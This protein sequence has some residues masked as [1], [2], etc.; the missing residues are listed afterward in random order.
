M[1]L[2]PSMSGAAL[3]DLLLLAGGR[4]LGD[5]SVTDRAR[6]EYV[7]GQALVAKQQWGEALA[8][9]ERS[10]ELRPH[11]LT[12]FNLGVCERNLGHY[13][14]ARLD[15][16]RATARQAGPGAGE[17]SKN[18]LD[19]IAAYEAEIEPLIARIHLVIVPADAALQVDGRPLAGDELVQSAR[20]MAAGILAPGPGLPIPGGEADVALDPGQHVFTLTRTGFA[21]AV[22][23]RAFR[24]GE[25][26]PLRI[27]ADLLPATLHVRAD[28]AAAVVR[29]GGYDVGMAPVEVS[30]PGGIYD[31]EVAR[32]GFVT[33]RGRINARPGESF[34][35]EA[36][37]PEQPIPLTQK[38]WFWTAIGVVV[39]GAAL[40]TYYLT[41][42]APTRPE[43]DGGGLGWVAHIP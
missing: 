8:A 41:R 2:S 11:A 16:Y 10:L 15:F 22:L 28:R 9:F 32:T 31:V 39:T 35:L 27:E 29:I 17:L 33:Y 6:A 7:S 3:L 5:D 14:R 18:Y 38:W 43:A 1:G 20:S 26:S 23:S 42:P 37:L 25:Q 4:A 40:S 12:L 30:R 34:D 36:H 19:D 21:S 24:A 13:T